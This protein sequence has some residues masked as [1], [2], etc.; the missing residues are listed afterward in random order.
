MRSIT[1]KKITRDTK[2]KN[3][4]IHNIIYPHLTP[5]NDATSSSGVH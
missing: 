1:T 2:D 4:P 3:E 5:S